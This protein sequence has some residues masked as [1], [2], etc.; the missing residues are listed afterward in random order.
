M[1]IIIHRVNTVKYLKTIPAEFGCEIDVRA[2]GKSL[3][4]NHNP[5]EGGESYDAF[6]DEYGSHGT[7][8]LN[9]KTAGIEDLALRKAREHGIRSLFVLDVEFPYIYQAERK[10]ERAI[11]VRYSEAEP[12]EFAEF[13]AG[14]VD[15][16]W[17]DTNTCL[18]VDRK[19]IPV[20]KRFKTCLVCPERWGR[21]QDIPAYRKQFE[22]LGYWPDAVMTALSCAETWRPD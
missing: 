2:E 11:A 17:I 1:E 22:Q 10:G 16:L 14:K 5:L 9:I 20:L 6:L 15:W 19:I 4:L 7:L 12:I 3:I 18:P 8:I 21:P 13:H